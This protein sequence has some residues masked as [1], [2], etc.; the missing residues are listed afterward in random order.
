VVLADVAGFRRGYMWFPRGTGDAEA[1]RFQE[2]A[3][4]VVAEA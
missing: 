1:D 2:D 3:Y 4:A